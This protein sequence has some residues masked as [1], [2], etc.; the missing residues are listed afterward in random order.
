M[1]T[2]LSRGIGALERDRLQ[3]AVTLLRMAIELAPDSP[4]AFNALGEAATRS[5]LVPEAIRSFKRAAELD[6][7]S[8]SAYARLA[9]L[10]ARSGRRTEARRSLSRA[11]KLS[12]NASQRRTIERL[13]AE[14]SIFANFANNA[15][16]TNHAPGGAPPRRRTRAVRKDS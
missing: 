8:F 6:S 3:E 4:E 14:N 2:I 12:S 15:G 11:I 5:M 1:Q 7:G 9:G 10:Y 13:V 16:L